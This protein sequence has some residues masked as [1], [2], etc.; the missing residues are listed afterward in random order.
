MVISS[1]LGTFMQQHIH[2]ITASFLDTVQTINVPT[3]YIYFDT[4]RKILL[5]S[6]TTN[7]SSVQYKK[8]IA[9]FK[10]SHLVG[11][12]NENVLFSFVKGIK[13]GTCERIK[14]YKMVHVSQAVFGSTQ[15]RS[16]Q[17]LG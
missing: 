14:N 1:P 17:N 9:R 10:H 4:Q 12:S 5:C 2:G 3:L 8:F 6:P 11:L 16:E 7:T 15:K 13:K